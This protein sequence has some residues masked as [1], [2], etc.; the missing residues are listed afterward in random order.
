MGSTSNQRWP[1]QRIAP[2]GSIVT[3]DWMIGMSAIS[4]VMSFRV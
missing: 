1:F 4:R 2:S 3:R